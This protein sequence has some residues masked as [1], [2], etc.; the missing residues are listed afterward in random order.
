[1]HVD[2]NIHE[3]RKISAFASDLGI[4]AKFVAEHG[5]PRYLTIG[6]E[7]RLTAITKKLDV[8]G[9][10]QYVKYRLDSDNRIELVV[11]ND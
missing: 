10:L 9:D 8:D 4:T 2:I 6:N 7:Q 3:T 11:F 1:M 5:W